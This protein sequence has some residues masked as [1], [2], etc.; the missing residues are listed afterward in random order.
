MSLQPY[1]GHCGD[2]A[3]GAVLVFA[4][5]A[6]EVR[7]LVHAAISDWFDAQ[8]IDVRVNRLRDHIDW[9]R[10]LADPAKAAAGTPHVIDDPL[11]CEVC[12][13]WGSPPAEDGRHCLACID[14]EA[15]GG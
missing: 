12:E 14:A 11:T 7:P 13:R 10:T 15:I 6:R 5:T 3:D 9:M 2:P 8:Y 4:N 1:M